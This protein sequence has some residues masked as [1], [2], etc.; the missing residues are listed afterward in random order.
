MFRKWSIVVILYIFAWI[1]QHIAFKKS[2]NNY[3]KLIKSPFHRISFVVCICNIWLLSTLL[4]DQFGLSGAKEF[5][6]IVAVILFN[7]LYLYVL[8][9]I[10]EN[11]SERTGHAVQD[12]RD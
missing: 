2:H 1:L 5:L 12:D 8:R 11:K 7:S 6:C 3:S 10:Y 9:I 4:I